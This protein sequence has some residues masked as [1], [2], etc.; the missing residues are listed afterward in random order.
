VLG[1]EIAVLVNEKKMAGQYE[2]IFNGSNLPSGLYLYS[3]YYKDK[4]HSNKM[5]LLK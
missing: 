2:V 1:K 5:L 3:I 4:I